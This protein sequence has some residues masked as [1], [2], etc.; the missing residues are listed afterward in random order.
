M[1]IPRVFAAPFE[2]QPL[3]RSADSSGI[4]RD[5]MKLNIPEAM[6]KCTSMHLVLQRIVEMPCGMD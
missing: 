2:N 1:V 6:H 5:E 4:D 3:L